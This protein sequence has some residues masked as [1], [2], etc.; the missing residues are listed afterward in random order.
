MVDETATATLLRVHSKA[1]FRSM[2]M[3]RQF[4]HGFIVT[5]LRSVVHENQFFKDQHTVEKKYITI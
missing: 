4:N 1:D 5:C 3:V 2:C